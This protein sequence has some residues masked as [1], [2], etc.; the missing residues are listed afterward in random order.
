MPKGGIF[1]WAKIPGKINSRRLSL[2]LLK[3]TGVLTTPGS[4]LGSAGE[5]YLRFSLTAS[6]QKLKE[7]LERMKK[8]KEIWG[9]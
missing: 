6:E 4:G 5:G 7:A 8:S 3:K 1:V 9:G 2:E